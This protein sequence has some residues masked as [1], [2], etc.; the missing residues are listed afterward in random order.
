MENKELLENLMK[1][2]LLPLAFIGDSVHTLFVRHKVLE[3]KSQKMNNYHTSASK[4]CKASHQAKVM[5]NIENILTETEADIVRRAR[6]SKPKHHAKNST[7][8]DYALATCFEVLIGYL[9]LAGN[10]DRL[11]EIL[12]I[13]LQEF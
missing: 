10:K 1:T 4:F 5:K 12:N 6:N 13:S 8:A 3:N 7:T 2:N 11:N 9:Y